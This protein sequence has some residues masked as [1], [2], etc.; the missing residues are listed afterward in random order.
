MNVNFTEDICDIVD[1]SDL[2]DICD[3]CELHDICDL[4]DIWEVSPRAEIDPPHIGVFCFVLQTAS[5]SVHPVY[6][7][8]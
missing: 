8:G 2:F 4:F 7:E 6:S 5:V 1:I 3:I